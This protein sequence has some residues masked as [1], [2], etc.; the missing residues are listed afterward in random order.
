MSPSTF[1]ARFC[2]FLLKYLSFMFDGN[3]TPEISNFVLVAT[4]KF[5]LMRRR[6]HAL[7]LKGPGSS[8]EK[9]CKYFTVNVYWQKQQPPKSTVFFEYFCT[10]NKKFPI[11]YNLYFTACFTHFYFLCSGIIQLGFHHLLSSSCTIPTHSSFH[12]GSVS[13][14]LFGVLISS[15]MSH[16]LQIQMHTRTVYFALHLYKT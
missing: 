8:K 2:L 11:P 10:Y 16:K 3:V 14:P 4:T 9:H 6:G 7:I 12:C 5:W 13:I 15:Q 1:F